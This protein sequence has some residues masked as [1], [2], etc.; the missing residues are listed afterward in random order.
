M[1]NIKNIL[2]NIQEDIVIIVIVSILGLLFERERERQLD[3][4]VQ[5]L[6]QQFIVE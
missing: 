3:V 2:I 1:K 4:Y 5:F 6:K